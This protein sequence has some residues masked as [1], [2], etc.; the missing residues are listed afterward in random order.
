MKRNQNGKQKI[1]DK[2]LI[3]HFKLHRNGFKLLRIY[4]FYLFSDDLDV[5]KYLY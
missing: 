3:D 4:H 1:Q 2:W 5:Q